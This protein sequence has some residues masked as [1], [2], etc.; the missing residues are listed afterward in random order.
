MGQS[1]WRSPLSSDGSFHP[2]VFSV[3][4]AKG[5]PLV[6][7]SITEWYKHFRQA[8][9]WSGWHPVSL[10]CLSLLK[11]GRGGAHILPSK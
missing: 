9:S 8:E 6:S 10:I 11:V 2:E 1:G 5:P 4:S 7:L 3:S